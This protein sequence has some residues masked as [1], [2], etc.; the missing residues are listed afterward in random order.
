MP[1]APARNRPARRR[2]ARAARTA[3]AGSLLAAVSL[4]TLPGTASATPVATDDAS[5]ERCGRVYPD[6]LAFAPSPSPV[7]G[8][9][10]SAKGNAICRS[11][12]YI[13]YSEAIDGMRY[14]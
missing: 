2:L 5:Y 4:V 14:L 9:S 1:V 3:L 6:P 13:Q 12:D 7:P 11:V 8:E 10:P